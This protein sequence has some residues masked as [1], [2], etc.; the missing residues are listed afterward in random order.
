MRTTYDTYNSYVKGVRERVC[1]CVCPSCF[2]TR[3]GVFFLCFNG[4]RGGG[5]VLVH[6]RSRMVKGKVHFEV[7]ERGKK[8]ACVRSKGGNPSQK[9]VLYKNISELRGHT[10]EILGKG[11]ILVHSPA[12]QCCKPQ[13]R[14][15]KKGVGARHGL[16]GCFQH[17]IL[18]FE[19]G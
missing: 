3:R 15:G 16:G 6:G 13:K 4:Q 19:A 7:V 10:P 11:G 18:E 9:R 12:P 2:H 5:V 14:A 17:V 1:K 8:G